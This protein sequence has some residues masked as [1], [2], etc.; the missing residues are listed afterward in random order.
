MPEERARR[1]GSQGAAQ[2]QLETPALHTLAA[3]HAP[4]KGHE[5]PWVSSGPSAGSPG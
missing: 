1:N 3:G 4:A 2:P 5:S